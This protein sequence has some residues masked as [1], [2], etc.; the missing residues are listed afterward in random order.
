[1]YLA[2]HC[3]KSASKRHL[4]KCIPRLCASP[5][6]PTGLEGRALRPRETGCLTLRPL[7]W[8]L[9]WTHL[10]PALVPAEN[11]ASLCLQLWPGP[12]ARWSQGGLSLVQFKERF[13]LASSVL[14]SAFGAGTQNGNPGKLRGV[15]ELECRNW[16]WKPILPLG[17]KRPVTQRLPAEDRALGTLLVRVSGSALGFGPRQRGLRG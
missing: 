10:L 2:E 17:V 16:I 11:Q 7:V 12:L 6:H 14:G 1:M 8:L 4:D 3:T 15:G 13:P 5:V 9:H